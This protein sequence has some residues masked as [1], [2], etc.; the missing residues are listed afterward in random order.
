MNGPLP[1]RLVFMHEL[2]SLPLHTKVRFLGC[3]AR[4]DI[5]QG[6]LELEHKF[7]SPTKDAKN[8]SRRSS[9]H[10][11]KVLVDIYHVLDTIKAD[12]LQ[13]GTWL[14]VFG[15]IRPEDLQGERDDAAV[16]VQ[17]VMISDAGAIRVAEYEQSVSDMQAINRRFRRGL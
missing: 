4:Y 12:E 11:T 15:Y 2:P 16:Y 7:S 3:V 1:T 8:K 9:D 17:A 10:T 13:I 6:R 5:K 14:N